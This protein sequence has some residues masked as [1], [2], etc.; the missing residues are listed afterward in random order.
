MRDLTAVGPTLLGGRQAVSSHS[1]GAAGLVTPLSETA[2]AP[3]QQLFLLNLLLQLFDGIATYNGLQM[4][5]HEGN[6]LLRNSFAY[7]GVVPSLLL[8][9][10][11]ACCLVV[12]LYHSV[13]ERLAAPALQ[14][15]AV[16]YVIGSLIPW[17]TAFVLLL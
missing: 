11:A 1:V 6:P 14:L 5:I 4:G 9:K 15:V 7:W 3:V 13:A 2:S 16:V 17:L 10:A 12:F 8:F